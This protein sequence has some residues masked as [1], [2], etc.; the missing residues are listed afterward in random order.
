MRSAQRKHGWRRQRPLY[1]CLLVLRSI[2]EFETG[3]GDLCGVVQHLERLQSP[4]K[5][6]GL[7]ELLQRCRLPPRHIIDDHGPDILAVHGIFVVPV[8]EQEPLGEKR[9]AEAGHDAPYPVAETVL[10]VAEHNARAACCLLLTVAPRELP[11]DL[12]VPL[13]V[14][15]KCLVRLVAVVVV[16]VTSEDT[17][18]S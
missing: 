16:V 7:K 1:N 13:C 5:A 15:V 8:D 6:R 17:V 14:C 4:V 9:H 3:L 18:A 2:D 12:S 10:R 11:K